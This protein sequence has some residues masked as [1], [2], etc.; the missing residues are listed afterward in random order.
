MTWTTYTVAVYFKTFWQP[1]KYF[2]TLSPLPLFNL[3]NLTNVLFI[4]NC[5]LG[6]FD[7]NNVLTLV[8]TYEDLWSVETC[9]ERIQ[10]PNCTANSTTDYSHNGDILHYSRLWCAILQVLPNQSYTIAYSSLIEAMSLWLT[11]NRSIIPVPMEGTLLHQLQSTESSSRY[12][13]IPDCYK[14]SNGRFD[15]KHFSPV[16]YFHVLVLNCTDAT[17][18]NC[19]L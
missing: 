2:T 12:L 4:L 17:Y 1:W 19:Q 16:F 8:T 14:L 13:Q 9:D 6:K 5:F 11:N 15:V 10:G 7:K 18:S 3:Q